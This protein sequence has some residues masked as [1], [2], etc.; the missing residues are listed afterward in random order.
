MSTRFRW[1][2]VICLLGLVVLALYRDSLAFVPAGV[3][4]LAILLT[5]GI[6]RTK[7]YRLTLIRFKP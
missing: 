5:H 2:S 3:L 1:F 4:L 6:P 7:A